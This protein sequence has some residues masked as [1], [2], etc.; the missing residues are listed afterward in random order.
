[1]E[2]LETIKRNKILDKLIYQF[3][4]MIFRFLRNL[5]NTGAPMEEKI[6]IISLHKIGDSIFTL[7]AIKFIIDN[8]GKKNVFLLTFSNTKIIFQKLID[9]SNI[10]VVENKD[11]LFENRIANRNVHKVVNK[12][13]P[14]TIVDLTGSII[15]ASIIFNKK[16]Y[17]KI[18]MNDKY[19]EAIYSNFVILDYSAH[20]VERYCSIAELYLNKK[21]DPIF[22]EYP[23]NYK[24]NGV[25][26]VNPFAGWDAKQW[27]L[28]KFIALTERLKRVYH[29]S[30]IFYKDQISDEIIDY[31][32]K[33]K[34]RF[35]QTDSIEMLMTE[36][37][38]SSLFVGNDSGP[39]Y[40]ANY[41][42]K[43]TFTIYGPTNPEYSKPF[44]KYHKQIKMNLKCIPLDSQYCFLSA[45]RKCPS[46]D[47]MA[48]LE[49]TS[50]AS[51]IQNFITTLNIDLRNP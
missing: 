12:N 1:M 8:V 51:E 4:N 13:K 21:I 40:L 10:I 41:L 47:C 32:M 49:E 31:F 30:I 50:V 2:I 33:N 46:Q 15:S 17:K 44:G 34:I 42:G 43:P 37:K 35:I 14:S 3:L 19:F 39:L 48:L 7:P 29:V 6:L 20:L 23:V 22:Y 16:S 9:E 24:N 26:L 45:G 28:R 38:K 5:L 27:G 11:F 25:I 36:I 18:G